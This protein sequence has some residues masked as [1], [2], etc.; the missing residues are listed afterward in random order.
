[1]QFVRCL[2]LSDWFCWDFFKS[3]SKVDGGEFT[4][5]ET[6]W[7]RSDDI[8]ILAHPVERQ[9]H[10]QRFVAS[11]DARLLVVDEATTGRWLEQLSEVCLPLS[12]SSSSIV[13]DGVH[14]ELELESDGRARCRI[15]WESVIPTEWASIEPII[16]EL[17]SVLDAAST[18]E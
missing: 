12:A 7:H 1:M 17:T 14:Y 11:V 6:R 5:S 15:Q 13:L 3:S 9:K 10:S 18:F 16:A 4:V 2:S 8:R